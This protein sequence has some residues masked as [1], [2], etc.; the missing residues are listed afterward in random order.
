MTLENLFDEAK[1]RL[2]PHRWHE[3][4]IAFY[5]PLNDPVSVAVECTRCYEVLIDFTKESQ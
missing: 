2:L 5:G 4:E 3:I 1:T